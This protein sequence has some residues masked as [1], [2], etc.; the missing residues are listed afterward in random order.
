MRKSD[1]KGNHKQFDEA[2]KRYRDFMVKVID[3]KR[4]IGSMQEKRDLAESVLL[5]LCANWESFVD[6][7]IV[8]CVNVDHTQLKEFLGVR[9]PAHPSKD[10]CRGLI[11]GDGYRDFRSFGDLKG[12]TKRVLPKKSNPFLAIKPVHARRIDEVYRIRN[13]LSHY[14]AKGRRALMAMYRD[15]YKMRRFLEPGQFLLAYN[16]RRLWAYF[17][18]FEGA[19]D[20]MKSCY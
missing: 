13:Y 9:I 10:L 18:T 8:D 17:D 20:D 16:S 7:H 1:L 3:A 4:V 11:F 19:S 15:R 14:S 12:F 2:V 6:E 5:R